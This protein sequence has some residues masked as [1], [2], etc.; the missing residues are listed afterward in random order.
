MT[1]S[2][3]K[4]SN[5]LRIAIGIGLLVSILFL[6][7]AFRNLQP[8]AFFESLTQIDLPLTFLGALIYFIAVLVIAWRWQFLLNQIQRISLPALTQLVAIGYMGNNV[9][10]LRAGEALRVFL[11][12]RNHRVPLAR[13][14]TTVLV[15]RVFDGIV[16]LSF[17]IIGLSATEIVSDDIR[18]V[19]TVALPIF[20]IAVIVFFTLALFPNQIRRL[21]TIITRFLPQRITDIINHLSDDVLEGLAGLR[22]PLYLVGAVFASY[23]TWA[24]EAFVY[25]IVMQAF[26]LE[27]DY[28]VA[29]LAVGTVNLAGLIPAVPGQIGVYEFFVSRVLIAVGI[30]EDTALAY[31]IVVHIVIW[32]PVTVVGFIFL[33]RQGLGWNS[34]RNARDLE[35]TPTM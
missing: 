9:Y 30:P 17:I 16:M 15:E 5:N 20:V 10:P 25:W 27:L 32:L 11:L 13:S 8:E 18:N 1:D 24:I 21:V 19:L 35:T 6:F 31:A 12:K 22:H 23:L 28:I 29:L 26:G 33:V 2:Q 4:Q 7:L 3:P 14:A 34:I